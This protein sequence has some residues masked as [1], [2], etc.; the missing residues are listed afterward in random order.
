MENILNKDK[1]N[2]LLNL[3][4]S[5]FSELRRSEEREQ[6]VFQWTTSLLLVSFGALIALS[7]RSIPLQ[8]PL[9][10]KLLASIMLTFPAT[11]SVV[12]MIWRVKRS[13]RN[14]DAVDRIRES[15]HLYEDGYYGGLL[16][17]Y[18]HYWKNAFAKYIVKRLETKYYIAIVILMTICVVGS[19]WIVI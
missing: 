14:A 7:D 11:F 10:I 6:V 9:A 12:W 3:L 5:Q 2:I 18:P 13:S 4:E 1:V 19:L 17:V 16:S 8:H 15:L